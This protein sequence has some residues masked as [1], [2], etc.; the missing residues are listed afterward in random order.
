MMRPKQRRVEM[1]ESISTLSIKPTALHPRT[2]C[3]QCKSPLIPR[4]Y[5]VMFALGEGALC[6]P[7]SAKLAPD[8]AGAVQWLHEREN[9]KAG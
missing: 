5:A 9:P 8:L 7:C 2:Q 3:A 4:T 1:N 6:D